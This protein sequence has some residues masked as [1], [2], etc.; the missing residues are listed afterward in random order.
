[1]LVQEL[2]PSINGI[3]HFNWRTRFFSPQLLHTPLS[4][5]SYFGPFYRVLQHSL[6]Q[7]QLGQISL[8]TH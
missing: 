8:N 2:H 5:Q 6:L 7:D 4:L 1:M 3:D